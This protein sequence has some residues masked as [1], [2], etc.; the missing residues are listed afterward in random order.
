MNGAELF[1][2]RLYLGCPQW[3]HRPWTES[4]YPASSAPRD[5]LEHYAQVFNTV[6]GN[7]TFY[8][9]PPRDVVMKWAAQTPTSF[10]LVLKLP[11][12]ITHERRLDRGALDEA[13]RFLDHMS[14]LGARLTH[15]LIQLPA[16]FD[17]RGFDNLYRFLCALPRVGESG[18]AREYMVE[19]RAPSLSL[20]SEGGRGRFEEVNA[21]LSEARAERVWMDTR[22]LRAAPLPLSPETVAAQ[23]KKPNLPVYPIGLGPSPVVRYVAHP[24]VEA[25]RPW[26]QAWAEV[27]ARWLD[28]GRTPYFFAHYPGETLAPHIARLFYELLRVERPSLPEAPI[29]PSERQQSLF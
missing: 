21:L 16:G 28:E 12:H 24:N 1:G 15:T 29:W 18:E 6:E 3:A 4:V 9:V 22:P 10:R 8:A 19:L 13:L 5:A 2:G 7:T 14:P 25:N 23:G 27:F 26:L 17:E 20:P 11:K